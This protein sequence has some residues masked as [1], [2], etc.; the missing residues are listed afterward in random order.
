MMRSFF[1]KKKYLAL[2]V[3]KLDVLRVGVVAGGE[4]AGD[5]GRERPLKGTIK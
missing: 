2:R 3:E 4:R 1:L 5:L